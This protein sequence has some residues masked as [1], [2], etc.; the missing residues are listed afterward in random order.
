VQVQ[1]LE[2]E[3]QLPFMQLHLIKTAKKFFDRINKIR[4]KGTY[5]ELEMESLIKDLERLDVKDFPLIPFYIDCYF[6]EKE[7]LVTCII[8]LERFR[9]VFHR[10]LKDA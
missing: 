3:H 8:S 9:S 2:L 1:T 6:E 10:I 4:E 5:A 7:R